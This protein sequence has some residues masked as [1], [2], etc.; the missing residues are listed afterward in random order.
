LREG[1]SIMGLLGNGTMGL[2][3]VSVYG[4][5][6]F[7]V[8]IIGIGLLFTLMYTAVLALRKYIRS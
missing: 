8:C 1:T 5:V 3:F 2:L 6:L 7:A 4:V